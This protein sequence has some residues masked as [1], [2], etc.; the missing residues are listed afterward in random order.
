MKI[1]IVGPGTLG[2]LI[3]ASLLKAGEDVWFL[4]NNPARAKKLNAN[5][6]KI[7]GIGGADTVKVNPVR[8][9]VAQCGIS[10]G[11]KA[12]VDPKEIGISDLI[13]I[14]VKSYDTEQAVKNAK[15]LIGDNSLVLTLQN[16]LG[17]PEIISEILGQ[18]KVVAGITSCG[19]T[20]LGDGEIRYSGKGETIIGRWFQPN[21]RKNPKKWYIPRRR[22]E[23]IA[24]ALKR[25]NI[26]TKI[27]DNIKDV[28]WSKLIIN[29]GINAL[30]AITRLKNGALLDCQWTKDIMRLSALEAVKVA[31]R[32]RVD[33]I[34]SDPVKKIESV[35]SS[36]AENVSSML[37]DVL[38][39]RR[40]EIDYIN[41]AI[42][43]EAERLEIPVPVNSALTNLIKAIEASY[44]KQVK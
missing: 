11:V 7:T 1:A 2:C 42:V 8:N 4:D 36:C 32:R 6:I 39:K 25:A 17:N 22:L 21:T 24:A 44:A 28:L 13:I 15:P 14:C 12:S 38:D 29:V 37:Q 35:C 16:G 19:S 43:S 5:G 10:N 26:E 23:D 18:E 9:S 31:K 3:G 34:Y 33:L 27:S 30:S 40:T 41:G 20:S